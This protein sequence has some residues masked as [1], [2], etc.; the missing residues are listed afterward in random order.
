MGKSCIRF[1]KVDEIP[2]ELI[3]ELTRKIS[4]ALGMR[5]GNKNK[6]ICQEKHISE[7]KS[8]DVEAADLVHSFIKQNKRK[9]RLI[10][11]KKIVHY[12]PIRDIT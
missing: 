9:I 4:Q 6:H 7:L 5:K 12:K 3:G 10:T 11:N 8:V 1:K 2:F